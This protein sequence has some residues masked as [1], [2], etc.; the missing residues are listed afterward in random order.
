M[1]DIVTVR[2]IAPTGTFVAIYWEHKH[3]WPQVCRAM[4]WDVGDES[5]EVE[6]L[7]ADNDEFGIGHWFVREGNHV[8]GLTR[9]EFR[10][11]F[12]VV[13]EDKTNG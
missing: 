12:E 11:R 7:I 6:V 5:D 4:G 8:V 2:P 3:E 13:E 1:A 10:E 9:A